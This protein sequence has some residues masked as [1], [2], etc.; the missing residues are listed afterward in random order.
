MRYTVGRR[1]TALTSPSPAPLPQQ[2]E[3]PS[4]YD[5]QISPLEQQF[6]RWRKIAGVF[7]TPIAFFVVY[8]LCDGLTP[9]GRM[10]SAILGAVATMWVSEVI[11]LPVT[12]LLGA[13]LCVVLKVAD[14]KTVLAYFGDPIV[15]VFIGGF[16]IAKAMSV[17]AL[18]RRIALYFLSIPI[19]GSTRIGMLAGLG[20]VTAFLSMWIS[21]TA[22]TAMMLPV[23]LGM[24]SA[25]H[26]L[27]VER[28][29]ASGEM[30]PR[31]WPFATAM[32]LMVAY[33][34]SIGGIGTPVG[35]PPNLI[36]LGLI[37]KSTGVDISFFQWMLLMLPLLA[38][39]GLLLLVL[40][41][42]LHPERKRPKK[43]TA[44]IDVAPNTTV[45]DYRPATAPT[46][47]GREVLDYIRA[48]RQL[49]GKWTTGQI[50]TL[51]AFLIAVTLWVMPG[52]LALPFFKNV[53]WMQQLAAWFKASMPESIVALLAASILFMLPT[54]L[55]KGEFTLSW[56]EAQKIDWGTIL[57]FGGGLA[58]GSLMFD[59]KVA[60]AMGNALTSQI[61]T[62]SLWGLTAISIVMAII[63]SEAT[64]NT[65]SANMV[66]PVVIAI[67]QSAGVDPLPP[68]LGACLG[69]SYGFMLPV[70]TPPNAI[71]YGSGLV[72]LSRMMRAGIVFDVLGFVVIFVGLRLLYPLVGLG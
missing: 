64:S 18:D 4:A 46:S 65:A 47:E 59:T 50:N 48:E 58:L 11:P 31:A 71:A 43:A 56:H 16:M 22:T 30:N 33:G 9:Q 29:E 1:R 25:L 6:E 14:A 52:V 39:M 66:I 49:L 35:S 36:G 51:V 13:A 67:S 60:E 54:K 37:R 55:S 26:K 17:H 5:E 12:A 63:L 41:Y 8:A 61:G 23:G 19:I 45:L 57:L 27:R 44:V 62:Q 28:G 32:M 69:A 40:L 2:S 15:F 38:A 42:V 7:L 72:P 21:N 20:F 10:L 3:Q 34:A 24:L 70:S 53:D 68:A